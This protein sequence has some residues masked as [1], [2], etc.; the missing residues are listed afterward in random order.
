MDVST[1]S[2]IL[3]YCSLGQTQEMQQMQETQERRDSEWYEVIR[4]R[5]MD[6]RGMVHCATMQLNAGYLSETLT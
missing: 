3:Q 4:P 6:P 5:T 1:L 2:P